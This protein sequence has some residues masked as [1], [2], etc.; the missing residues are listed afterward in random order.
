MKDR[1]RNTRYRK[2]RTIL[3]VL[4]QVMFLCLWVDY[5]FAAGATDSNGK[6]VI[7]SISFVNNHAVKSSTLRNK[8]DFKVGDY[9]DPILAEAYR[10]TIVEFYRKKG[11]A[12]VSVSLDS[13]MLQQG[14]VVYIVDEG[15][16]VKIGSVNFVGNKSIKTSLLKGVVK[17]KKRKAYFWPKYYVEEVPAEDVAR[18]QDIYYQKGFLDYDISVKKEVTQDRKKVKSLVIIYGRVVSWTVT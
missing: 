6:N 14:D 2:Q 8:L 5:A 12:Y 18:L 7:K 13:S 4:V 11:Y 9:L 10:R 17:T 3:I 1:M 15:P 16:R